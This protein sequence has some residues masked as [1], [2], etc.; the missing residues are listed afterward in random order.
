MESI[1]LIKSTGDSHYKIGVSKNP[2]NRVK[3]LQT[4]NSSPIE[5][6]CEYETKRAYKIEKILH[7]RF[8]YAHKN[9]EWYDLSVMEESNFLDECAKIDNNITIL[10]NAGNEF[11]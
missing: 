4:G 6:V 9:G 10:E 2:K 3:Q 7:R 5:L 1:Y 8:S 11:I